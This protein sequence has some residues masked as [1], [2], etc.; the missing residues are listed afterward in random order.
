M[1]SVITLC[2]YKISI[3]FNFTYIGRTAKL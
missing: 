3:T 2:S 1:W